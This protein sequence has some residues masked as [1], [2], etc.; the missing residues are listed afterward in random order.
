MQLHTNLESGMTWNAF[1]MS[2]GRVQLQLSS[3]NNS[4]CHDEVTIWF[5]PGKKTEEKTLIFAFN[6]LSASIVACMHLN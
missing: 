4:S 6:E 2:H 5:S 1:S 3:V